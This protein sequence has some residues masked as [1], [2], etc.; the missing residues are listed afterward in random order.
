[1]AAL[2]YGNILGG[3]QTMLVFCN[4]L[5][6]LM[7]SDKTIHKAFRS[8]ETLKTKPIREFFITT[9]YAICFAYSYCHDF[10][11]DGQIHEG[12]IL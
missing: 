4:F 2:L 10:G 7:V 5:K 11:L 3:I 12:L 8:H 9:V 6:I 1:M